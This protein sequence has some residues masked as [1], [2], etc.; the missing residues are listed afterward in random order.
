MRYNQIMTRIQ[1][2]G[3]FLVLL[4]AMWA[5]RST[6]TQRELLASNNPLDQVTATVWLA[7]RGDAEAVHKLVSLLEDRDRTVRM[8]AIQA[9]WQL[10]GRTYGYKFYEPEPSRARAVR[11]WRN[12]LRAGEVA[13]HP[14][15]A[16][17]AAVLEPGKD[18][19]IQ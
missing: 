17:D 12:A 8:Y 5:C 1:H 6:S 13:L 10:C 18:E 19:R 3:P 15:P 14:P 2:L 16:E 7:E 9:L 4:L 11:Q